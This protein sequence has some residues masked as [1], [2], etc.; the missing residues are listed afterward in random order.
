[1]N[2]EIIENIENASPV[3]EGK[4]NIE[5]VTLHLLV[6]RNSDAELPLK[7]KQSFFDNCKKR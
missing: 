7:Y 4:V 5:N 3:R 1:M 2:N 6:D